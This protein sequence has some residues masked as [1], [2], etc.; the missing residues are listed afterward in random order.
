MKSEET[1]KVE[2]K[3]VMRGRVMRERKNKAKNE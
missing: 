3:I 1:G 2:E